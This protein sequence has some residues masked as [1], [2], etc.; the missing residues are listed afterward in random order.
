MASIMR[1]YSRWL[2]PALAGL[3]FPFAAGASNFSY[4]WVEGSYGNASIDDSDGDIDGDLWGISGAW[5]FHDY[6]FVYGGYEYGDFDYDIETDTYQ[7]GVGLAFPMGDSVDLVAGAAYV[8]VSTDVPFFGDIDDD[9]YSVIAGIRAGVADAFQ[10]EAGAEYVDLDDAGSDTGYMIGG[11]YYFTESFA[12]G[13]GYSTS[14]DADVW[15]VT[16]RWELP[17]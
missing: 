9:G 13:A 12:V 14:D 16:L 3:L 4:T 11:R 17:R 5:Q 2:V 10:I 7:F 8:D 6:V 1:R 15:S